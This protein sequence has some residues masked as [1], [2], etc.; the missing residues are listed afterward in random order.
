MCIL[1]ILSKTATLISNEL[2]DFKQKSKIKKN[3]LLCLRLSTY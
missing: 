1:F 2:V 3:E